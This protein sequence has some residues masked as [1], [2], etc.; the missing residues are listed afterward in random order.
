MPWVGVVFVRIISAPCQASW[1]MVGNLV[2]YAQVFRRLSVAAANG[3]KF[4]CSR[5]SQALIYD[6]CHCNTRLVRSATLINMEKGISLSNRLHSELRISISI[7]D[8]SSDGFI[9]DRQTLQK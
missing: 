8:E 9:T 6:L 5:T 1:A 7:A 3:D 4:F 2:M